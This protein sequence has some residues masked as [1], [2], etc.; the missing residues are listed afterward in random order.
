MDI[1]DRNTTHLISN[2]MATTT[3]TQQID[4]KDPVCGMSVHPD[5]AAGSADYEGKKFYFCSTHCLQKFREAPERFISD[6]V[7]VEKAP[8]VGL[9]HVPPA[10]GSVS[11]TCPMHPEIVRDAPGNCPIC[12]MALEP[13]VVSLD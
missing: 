9:Q 12:G 3:I 6:P 13:R 11:Y 10:G 1:Q 4:F 8:V 5:S 7:Q 2:K